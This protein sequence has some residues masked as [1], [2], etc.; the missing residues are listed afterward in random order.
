MK[1]KN[2]TMCDDL[3]LVEIPQEI[4][5][6]NLDPAKDTNL[7]STVVPERVILTMK[8]IYR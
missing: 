2:N 4:Q 7:H 6:Y 5:K 3:L 8:L 1:G